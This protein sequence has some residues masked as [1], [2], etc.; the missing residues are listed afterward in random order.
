MQQCINKC[1]QE[2]KLIFNN[3]NFNGFNKMNIFKNVYSSLKDEY[4]VDL[5]ERKNKTNIALYNLFAN[6][7]ELQIFKNLMVKNLIQNGYELNN[8]LDNENYFK[9]KDEL[10]CYIKTEVKKLNKK[11]QV[12]FLRDL[13]SELNLRGISLYSRRGNDKKALINF[14][15]EDEIKIVEDMYKKVAYKYKLN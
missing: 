4:G 7:K 15:N 1:M 5:Y 12:D 6:E 10:I 3:Y 14:I 2:F 11:E 13:Y 8:L 9:S